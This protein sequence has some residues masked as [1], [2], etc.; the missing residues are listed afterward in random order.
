VLED[1]ANAR[2]KRKENIKFFKKLKKTKSKV[3]DR[4]IHPIHKEVF[5][6]TNCL[7]CAN[8]CKTTGPLFTDKD[9]FSISKFLKIKPS[10]FVEKYLRVDEE[11]DYVLKTTPCVFLADDNSCTIYESRPKACRDFPHTDRVKQSQLL[12]ITQKNYEICPAV[13]KIIEKLKLEIS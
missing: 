4:L 9:I 13:Y 7:E 2:L 11:K 10:N 3:L 8:C 12:K 6:C 5:S 1:L